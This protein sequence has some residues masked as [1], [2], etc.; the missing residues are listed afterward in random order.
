[1]NTSGLTESWLLEVSDSLRLPP[2]SPSVVNALLPII[3]LQLRR[4]IQ[5]GNKFQR[6]SKSSTLKGKILYS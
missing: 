2:L 3:E 4:I 1:M 6:R 5:Q